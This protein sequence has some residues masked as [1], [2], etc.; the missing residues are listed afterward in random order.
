[1]K[2]GL[3]IHQRQAEGL[4]VAKSQGKHLGRPQ[5]NLSTLSKKQLFIIEETYPKWKNREITGVKFMVLL[6]LKKNTFYKIVKEY[7]EN[8]VATNL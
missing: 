4:A 1:M 6:E 5:L 2:K 7:E 3:T 8:K